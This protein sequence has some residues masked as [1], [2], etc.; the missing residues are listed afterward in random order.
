M[1]LRVFSEFIPQ[2][3]GDPVPASPSA[4]GRVGLVSASCTAPRG[5]AAS[6]SPTQTRQGQQPPFNVHP[7]R[8][9]LSNS[10]M[11]PK[12]LQVEES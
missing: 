1:G 7:S 5:P 9:E 2:A 11:V 12:G 10:H 8:S 3:R 6:H 4:S